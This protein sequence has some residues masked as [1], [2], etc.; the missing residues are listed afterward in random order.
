MR[1]SRRDWLKLGALSGV[2]SGALLIGGC[3]RVVRRATAPHFSAPP[4]PPAHSDP[5]V[6]LLNRVA[7]GP[8]PGDVARVAKMGAEKYVDAQLHPDGNDE[9]ILLARLRSVE[10]FSTGALEMRDTHVEP[11]LRGLQQAAILRAV[12]SRHQLLERMVDFWTNH[13]NIYARKGDGTYFLPTDQLKVIRP[14]ALGKFP[15]LLKASAHSPAM[16]AYLDN[17]VNRKGRAN[18]NYARELMELHTL[19]VRGGYSQKDVQEVARC[20]TGWTIE[21]R[22]LRRNKG[23]FRF[24]AE[25]HDNGEKVVLG[26]RIPANG[27]EK[28]AERVLD[29]LVKHPQTAKYISEKLCRYFLGEEVGNWPQKIARIY[30]KTGGDIKAMLRPLLLSDELQNGPPIIKR[31]FDFLVSSLRVLGAD[32]AAGRPLQEQ[33]TRMGQPL[34]LWPMPD[35]YPDQT[36]AWTGSLLA[37]WNFAIAL[38]HNRIEDTSLNLA[39]LIEK[40]AAAP[41]LTEIILGHSAQEKAKLIHTLTTNLDDVK[42]PAKAASHIAALL[43]CTPEFQWR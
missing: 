40:K 42:D 23:Q 33:L 2:S 34:H 15:E 36:R 11:M 14:H 37:R 38:T 41:A 24:D 17:N 31:P 27:G 28:D 3:S 21:D 39:A 1:I 10:V 43:L 4:S 25:R 5:I 9:M 6:R 35:G 26:Q 8:T 30:L 19:G 13:F 32:T 7:F 22:F 18:E 16:L 20:F 29:I 12:Y